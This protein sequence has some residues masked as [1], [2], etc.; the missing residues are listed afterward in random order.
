LSQPIEWLDI[1]GRR[2][3]PEIGPDRNKINVSVKGPL[4]AASAVFQR[5]IS[6]DERWTINASAEAS[7]PFRQKWQESVEVTGD[8]SRLPTFESHIESVA[9]NPQPIRWEREGQRLALL[10]GGAGFEAEMSS[11]PVAS[12]ADLL[13]LLQDVWTPKAKPRG[14]FAVASRKLFAIRLESRAPAE[15]QGRIAVVTEPHE[16][17]DWSRAFQVSLQGKAYDFMLGWS[18]SNRLVTTLEVKAPVVGRV[19]AQ[20]K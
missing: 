7:I 20:I 16:V 13:F 10:A 6:S 8:F 14:L 17:S 5:R 18:E 3:G 2:P 9:S 1:S 15:I 12:S 19:R 11:V 4:Y